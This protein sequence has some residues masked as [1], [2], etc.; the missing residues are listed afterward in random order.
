MS[1]MF[2][3]LCKNLTL[4]STNS[5]DWCLVLHLKGEFWVPP[6]LLK[7]APEIRAPPP[8]RVPPSRRAEDVADTLRQEVTPSASKSM[9]YQNA[10]SIA[11][12]QVAGNSTQETESFQLRASIKSKGNLFILGLVR[13]FRHTHMNVN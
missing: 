1:P 4:S 9:V 2:H 6:D 7:L 11:D 13:D 8:A 12:V 10:V 5:V 3:H